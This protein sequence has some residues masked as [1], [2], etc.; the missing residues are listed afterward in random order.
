MVRNKVARPARIPTIH[1]VVLLITWLTVAAASWCPA[2]RPGTARPAARPAGGRR[3][4]RR[5]A[6]SGGMSLIAGCLLRARVCG[7][8]AARGGRG[9]H[10]LPGARGRRDV[11]GCGSTPPAGRPPSG[12]HRR[13]GNPRTDRNPVSGPFFH[14]G[15]S[16]IREK[17]VPDGVCDSLLGSFPPHAKGGV[18]DVLLGR[19]LRQRDALQPVAAD[20]LGL[21]G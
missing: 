1:T 11:S 8:G 9:T 10:L 5:Q 4:R 20:Q 2:A 21:P 16:E 12:M 3:G 18:A 14:A 13:A 6:G 7:A 17:T 15:R 19:D